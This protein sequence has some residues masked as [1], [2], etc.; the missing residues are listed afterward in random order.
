DEQFPVKGIRHLA[1]EGPFALFLGAPARCLR[2]G[3]V[4]DPRKLLMLA[5]LTENVNIWGLPMDVNRAKL[6]GGL[7]RLTQDIVAQTYP[8]VS[9]DGK[10]LAFSS[11]RSGNRDIWLKDLT[12]GREIVVVNT[13]WPEFKP[14]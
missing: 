3:L 10:K 2:L 8:V 12:T 5:S 9:P 1:H 7:R 11:R 4:L 13:H 14:L 6:A